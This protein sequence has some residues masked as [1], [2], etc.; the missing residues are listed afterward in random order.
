MPTGIA[1]PRSRKSGLGSLL[2]SA[3]LAAAL[4]GCEPGPS[5]APNSE[6]VR[7]VEPSPTEAITEL[8]AVQAASVGPWRRLPVIPGPAFVAPFEAGC[9]AAEPK[10]RGQRAAVID[11]RGA[12]IVTLVYDMGAAA[13]V[14]RST[15]DDPAKPFDVRAIEV[16][17]GELDPDGIDIA[18]YEAV[19][20]GDQLETLLVGRIG[21]VPEVA[22]VIAGFPDQTFVWGAHAN[23]WYTMWWQGKVAME[24]VA[25]T[26]IRHEVLSE[27]DQ[28]LP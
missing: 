8:D 2:S 16:P 9:Q 12:K 18:F 19:R 22:L 25:T 14:C 13:F 1:E 6:P 7:T 17:T 23:G 5:A 20:V 24:G 10:L 11:V 3:L 27:A 28:P 4:I 21:P 15:T 26:N